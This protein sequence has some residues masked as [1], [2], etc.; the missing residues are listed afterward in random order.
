MVQRQIQKAEQHRLKQIAEEEQEENRRRLRWVQQLAMYQ[1]IELPRDPNQNDNSDE[2]G[3][4]SSFYSSD[5]SGEAN[6]SDSNGEA[7]S[8]E[9]PDG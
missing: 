4:S 7:I 5:P 9:E 2:L 1:D 8:A 6:Q 3:S